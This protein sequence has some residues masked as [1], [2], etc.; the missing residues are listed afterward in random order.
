M[1]WL[2]EGPAPSSALNML[3][4]SALSAH[5]TTAAVKTLDLNRDCPHNTEYESFDMA[6]L[7]GCRLLC[8]LVYRIPGLDKT[9]CALLP[10][11]DDHTHSDR[12][13]CGK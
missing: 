12:R 10:S 9:V 6:S 1:L 5:I 13:S 11:T 2:P 8:Y 4:L 3:I 7:S